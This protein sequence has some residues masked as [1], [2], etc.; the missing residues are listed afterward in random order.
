MLVR[1]TVASRKLAIQ[2]SRYFILYREMG[3][4]FIVV[5]TSGRNRFLDQYFVTGFMC[6]FVSNY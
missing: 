5:G 2:L 6:R 4:E 3:L 1:V